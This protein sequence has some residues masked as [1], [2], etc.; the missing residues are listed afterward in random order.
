MPRQSN[1]A[2]TR[3]ETRQIQ[4]LTLRAAFQPATFNAE[5][6]SVEIVWTT[7]AKGLRRGW[8]GDYYEELSLDASAVRLQRLNNGAPLLAV[9]NAM[10]LR[11]VIGVVERAW[12]TG[13][14]GRAL[15]RFSERADADEIMNDVR[16]GILR[17]ISVGYDVHK[18]ERIRS[19]GS[20]GKPDGGIDTYRAIDWEPMEISIVPIGFDDG[21]KV[22]SGERPETH[23]VE[24]ITRRI[25]RGNVM[26]KKRTSTIDD[27]VDAD[28]IGNEE[29][30]TGDEVGDQPVTIEARAAVR[31]E[32]ARVSTILT[33][34]RKAGLG[35]DFAAEMIRSGVPLAE[36]RAAIIDEMASEQQRTQ[37]NIRSQ[38]ASEFG[39]FLVSAGEDY[40]SPQFRAQ[41]MGEAI[42]ARVNPQ[43]R[44]SDASRPYVGL[45]LVELARECLH[46]RGVSTRSMSGPRVI[47]QALSR[48][49]HGVSDFAL[50]LG[51]AVGRELHRAFEN[52]EP[53]V[54]RAGRGVTANDFRARYP[55]R[56]GDAPKLE[57][58]NEHGEFKRGTIIEAAEPAWRLH[59]YGKI[60]GITRQALVNDDIGAFVDLPGKMGIEA[61]ELESQT[62][63]DL[64]ISNSGSGPTMGDGVTLFHATHGNLAATGGAI[65]VT[66]LGTA[67]A[68]MRLQKNLDGRPVNFSPKYLLIPAALETV[69]EQLLTQIEATKPADTNPFAGKLELIVDPRLDAASG[70]RWFIVADPSRYDGLQ[71][72][73]LAGEA[74]PIV[75]TQVGFDVDGTNFKVR[76]DFG[77]GFV[78]FRSWYANAG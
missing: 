30:E 76:L 54:L 33:L 7:G 16:A 55:V 40:S 37:G 48:A 41:A 67:R 2:A 56:I 62:V 58:V 36:A 43:H 47:E 8:D 46:S 25:G 50:A 4:T 39:G 23:R 1:T 24:I 78:E 38:H 20:D 44:P 5:N 53:G 11:A 75:D 42:H 64:L 66:T 12:I 15:V 19:V 51:D 29:T 3:S 6:R 10:S 27:K 21:A 18:Y 31:T 57:R 73:H 9:H 28:Q 59:T 61:R 26:K 34:S 77:A 14:E 35:D 69:A 52:A 68:A 71:Y 22:R 70:T 45:T 72:A 63:V 49:Y 32:R 60:F 13:K 74:G 65:G 17:N